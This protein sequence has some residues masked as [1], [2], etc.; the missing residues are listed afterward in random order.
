M[1]N[2]QMMTIFFGEDEDME[3]ERKWDI[4]DNLRCFWTKNT[5]RQ[6]MA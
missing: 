2:R 5:G 6:R 3:F 1:V 4:K